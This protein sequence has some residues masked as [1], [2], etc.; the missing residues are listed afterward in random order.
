MVCAEMMEDKNTYEIHFLLQI[1]RRFTETLRFSEEGP[2]AGEEECMPMNPTGYIY[3]QRLNTGMCKQCCEDQSPASAVVNTSIST[4]SLRARADDFGPMSEMS[5]T[6]FV[7]PHCIQI[8]NDQEWREFVWL[9]C[10][11]PALSS[12]G[13]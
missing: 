2:D 1:E 5:P 6:L 12:T 10:E 9:S 3:I 4:S 13:L 8:E 11:H 7:F